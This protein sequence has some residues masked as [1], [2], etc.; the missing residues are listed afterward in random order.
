[1]KNI[2]RI[3]QQRLDATGYPRLL[4]HS[5]LLD[6][7]EEICARGLVPEGTRSVRTSVFFARADDATSKAVAARATVC[8]LV[9]MENSMNRWRG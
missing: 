5:S 4:M 8:T 3:G 9:E 1:M 6:I 7:M 2:Q